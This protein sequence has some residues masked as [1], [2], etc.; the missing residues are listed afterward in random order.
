MIYKSD[1]ERLIKW[2]DGRLKFIDYEDE[3]LVFVN[4]LREKLDVH[5]KEFLEGKE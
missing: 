2:V 5:F 1:Y 3:A 4:D